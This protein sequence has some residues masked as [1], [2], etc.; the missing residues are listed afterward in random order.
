M[1]MLSPAAEASTSCGAPGAYGP[2]TPCVSFRV[3]TPSLSSNRAVRF[4][5]SV[6]DPRE[7]PLG[8]ADFRRWLVTRGLE[9]AKCEPAQM[10]L[11]VAD[12]DE[13]SL[14]FVTGTGGPGV[15]R[16]SVVLQ[17]NAVG[18]SR[19]RQVEIDGIVDSGADVS[20]LPFEYAEALG[21]ADADLRHQRVDV[22]GGH[23]DAWRAAYPVGAAVLGMPEL[24]FELCPL[25][26][27]GSRT[28]LWGRQDFMTAFRVVVDERAQLL[29]LVPLIAI[30]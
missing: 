22:A 17:L 5:I 27:P 4:G 26:V 29:T 20:A 24:R 13:I 6:P 16:P 21:Y 18:T 14:S 12:G 2:K 11:E 3:A 15:H 19:P 7:I 30:S 23:V 28:A 25:F 10:R 9:P 1:A 8:L